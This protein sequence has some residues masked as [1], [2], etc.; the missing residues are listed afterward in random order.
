MSLYSNY[1]LKEI[2][3]FVTRKYKLKQLKY[4]E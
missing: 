1:R 2:T 4:L 3:S